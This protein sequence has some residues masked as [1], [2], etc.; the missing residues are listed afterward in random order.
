MSSEESS[1][2]KRSR[3]SDSETEPIAK[4]VQPECDELQT[5]EIIPEQS[6]S[7][8]RPRTLEENLES[9]REYSEYDD[10]CFDKLD[11]QEWYGT[12]IDAI[13]RAITGATTGNA[14]FCTISYCVKD[15]FGEIKPHIALMYKYVFSRYHNVRFYIE[16]LEEPT[17]DIITAFINPDKGHIVNLPFGLLANGIRFS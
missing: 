13:N 10:E 11:S 1:G 15:A 5:P 4:I 17:D 9:A 12:L 3:E 7:D 16:N 6:D 14:G 2:T 8:D